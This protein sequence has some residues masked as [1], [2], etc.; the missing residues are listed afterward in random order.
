[1]TTKVLVV[2]AASKT[3]RAVVEQALKVGHEVTA[4]VYSDNAL[5][6]ITLSITYC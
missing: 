3:G 4:L 1:M 2:G 5:F 6:L